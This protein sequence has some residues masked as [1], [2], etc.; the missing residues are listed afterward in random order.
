MRRLMRALLPGRRE[1]PAA[2]SLGC[3]EPVAQPS[4]DWARAEAE[5]LMADD[6]IAGAYLIGEPVDAPP[7][8]LD[9]M[10]AIVR[11]EGL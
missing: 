10:D 11:E 7:P 2:P 3:A 8:V 1:T 9:A 5:R 6:E 4:A